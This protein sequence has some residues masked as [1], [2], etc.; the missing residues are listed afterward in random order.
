MGI[1]KKKS[2]KVTF[3]GK[4]FRFLVREN[5][6]PWA[7][8]VVDKRIQVTVQEDVDQPGRVL[9]VNFPH[10]TEVSSRVVQKV[11]RKAF[12]AGWKPSERGAV[13]Q[14][15]FIDDPEF[16]SNPNFA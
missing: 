4:D 6:P 16:I 11:L 7:I 13:F 8:R 10:G 3:D 5:N 9:Q 15:G 14:L 1:P 12:D 2:R